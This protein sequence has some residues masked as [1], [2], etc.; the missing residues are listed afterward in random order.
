M[1]FDEFDRDLASI[2]ETYQDGD[3]EFW[4]LEDD[5]TVAGCVGVTSEGAERCELHRLYLMPSYRGRGMGRTLIETVLSWCRKRGCREVYLW[6][7]IKF[8]TAREVYIRCGFSPSASTRAID[9][10]NPG[11]VE[12][13]FS[14]EI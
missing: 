5:G 4:V 3:G 12:R 14:I 7:D 11:S 9:P 8:E 2:P 13:Y 1:E 6:S 10:V